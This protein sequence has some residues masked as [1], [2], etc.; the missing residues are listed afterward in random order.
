MRFVEIEH[1]DLGRTRV[2]ESRVPHLSPGWT[3]VQPT[4]QPTEQPAEPVPAEQTTRAR[5]ARKSTSEED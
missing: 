1:P 2:P 5:R 3:V 4:V